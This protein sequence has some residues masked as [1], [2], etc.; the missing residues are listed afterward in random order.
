MRAKKTILRKE[1]GFFNET[2]T[3][4]TVLVQPY[5]MLR[6]PTEGVELKGNARFEGYA[7]GTSSQALFVAIGCCQVF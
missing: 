6:K 5:T 7:V 2:F 1:T 4:T 3:I